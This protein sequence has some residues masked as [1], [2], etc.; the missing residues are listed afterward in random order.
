MKLSLRWVL[1]HMFEEHARPCE[2]T[3]LLRQSIDGRL[4][5]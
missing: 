1:I 5:E 4:D 2:Q 3:D